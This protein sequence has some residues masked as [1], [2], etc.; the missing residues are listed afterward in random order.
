MKVDGAL[1]GSFSEVAEQAA[2]LEAEG[3][4]G[5]VTAETGHDPFL[6]L[7]AAASVT[8]H[9]ELGTGI[10]VAFARTPMVLAATA[11]DLHQATG[12]RFTLGL[13]S[14]IKP[15]IERRFSMPWS[16]PAPRMREFILA[17]RAIWNTWNT[18]EKLD[19]RGEFYTHTL[20][21]PF[22]SPGPNP[23][24]P[25]KVA[26]AAVGEKM[27][28]VAGEVA[29]GI[30][31][32]PFTTDRYVREHTLPALE[33]GFA[34]GG[35]TRADFEINYPVFIVTGTDDATWEKARTGTKQQIAFYGSTPGYHGVLELHGWHEVGPQLNALS[36]KGEWVEMGELIT[37][38]MLETFA[39]VAEP[40]RAAEAILARC[41][42][43]VDR[44]SFYTSY[45]SD[46]AIWPQVVADLQRLG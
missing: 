18:G 10:A 3:Y 33:R 16:H 17:L 31:L 43:L 13:G 45:Q 44:I 39:V 24:G 36:R 38:E 27:T 32:H 28:E 26:L 22:F 15:H 1:G 8:E 21:T 4:D 25:P 46:P 40:G 29:D 41:D 2:R 20:M 11:N 42:G 37:D 5:A 9:L 7:A 34:A 23:Y 12:G 6:P 14:Q 30:I 35:R 19:F